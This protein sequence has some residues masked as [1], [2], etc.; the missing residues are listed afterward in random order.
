MK[1]QNLMTFLFLLVLSSFV[2][3]ETFQYDANGNLI[4]DGT[5]CY[6]YNAA[7]RLENVTN[8]EGTLIARY[9][10]DVSG[11]KIKSNEGGVITY[12]PFDGYEARVNGSR[13]EN[14]TYYFVGGEIV[15][16]KDSN[17]SMHYYHGDQLG[18]TSVI[19]DSYG[20][21]E[22]TTKYYPFGGIRSGGTKTK[23]LYTGQEYLSNVGFYDYG[24]RQ[25]KTDPPTFMQPDPIIPDPLDPQT[26]NRYAYVRN[27][28]MKYTD[29]TGHV[30]DEALDAGFILMDLDELYNDPWNPWNWGALGADVACAS[31]PVLTGGS[32]VVKAVEHGDAAKYSDEALENA[33]RGIEFLE[34]NLEIVSKGGD[35]LNT[36]RS[37]KIGGKVFWME[38]SNVEHMMEHSSDFEKA[39]GPTI[40]EGQMID[41]AVNTIKNAEKT[42]TNEGGK[43]E[44]YSR[45]MVNGKEITMLTV[46]SKEGKVITSYPVNMKGASR[47]QD[48]WGTSKPSSA[49]ER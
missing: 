40:N 43:I 17:G 1:I 8:C 28:P 47:Y 16:R 19:T 39:F 46:T 31:V 30:I 35:L 29:S 22:E 6:Q 23:Y 12:Y 18:S 4:Q 45:N 14:T 9:W 48:I 36:V 26:L 37:E 21:V 33:G 5:Q 27:N 34:R 42:I 41:T 20:N 38:S 7:N 44:Y 15:A 32:K 10:Y 25:R 2:F 49:W 24:A 11:R 13:L 3:S